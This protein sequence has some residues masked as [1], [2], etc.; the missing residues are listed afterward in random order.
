MTK[1]WRILA[2]AVAV[3]AALL[4]PSAASGATSDPFAGRWASIDVGDGSYQTLV[5]H[6]TGTTGH[7]GTR[8]YDTVA[9]QACA[10]Q[11]AAVQGPG[12]VSGD[13]MRV[14]FTVTCPG[15][16]RGPVSGLVGPITYTYHPG[17]D[18]MTDD[19]GDVWHR[20]P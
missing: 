13:E 11:P 14:L 17:T 3:T 7:H 10:G 16:G 19:A 5:V 18:T 20:L 15:S 9:S 8:L 2:A 6:G 1:T 12:V 4:T